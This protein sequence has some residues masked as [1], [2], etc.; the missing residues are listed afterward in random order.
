MV[1]KLKI[2]LFE[3][4][5]AKSTTK[6]KKYELGKVVF[7]QLLYK[8]KDSKVHS[9]EREMI[10]WFLSEWHDDK[11]CNNKGKMWDPRSIHLNKTPPKIKILLHIY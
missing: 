6:V 7:C 8:F 11:M 9:K 1:S 3:E 5:E 2:L 10:L 4:I